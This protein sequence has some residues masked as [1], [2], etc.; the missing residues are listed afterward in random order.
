MSKQLER[1]EAQKSVQKE[2]IEEKTWNELAL[3]KQLAV[4]QVMITGLTS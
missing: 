2:K 4:I 3:V 1:E